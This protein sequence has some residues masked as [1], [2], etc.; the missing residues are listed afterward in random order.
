MPNVKFRKHKIVLLN[1]F[2]K[3]IYIINDFYG[4]SHQIGIWRSVP[5]Q[6]QPHLLLDNT[7]ILNYTAKARLEPLPVRVV[8]ILVRHR[9]F[10]N[11]IYSL[12]E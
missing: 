9:L 5:G 1:V 11:Q 8:T 3:A 4:L 7:R 6:G 2:Y 10:I 12:E